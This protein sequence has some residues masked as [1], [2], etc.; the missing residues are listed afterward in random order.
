M[1]MLVRNWSGLTCF[2]KIYPAAQINRKFLAKEKTILSQ[3]VG[4]K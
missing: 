3:N 2:L 4:I 1:K